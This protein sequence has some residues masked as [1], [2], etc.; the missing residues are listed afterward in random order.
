MLT[1]QGIHKVIKFKI[2]YYLCLDLYY[3]DAQTIIDDQLFALH[4][5]LHGGGKQQ[6]W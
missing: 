4:I 2:L 5:D 1:L 3:F 6:Q